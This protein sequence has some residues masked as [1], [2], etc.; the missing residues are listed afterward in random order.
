[1]NQI[2][3]AE[4]KR[5]PRV[6]LEGRC[7]LLAAVE[8]GVVAMFLR[9]KPKIVVFHLDLRSSLSRWISLGKESL[10]LKI[11]VMGFGKCYFFKG[12]S[13]SGGMKQ[14]PTVNL[15]NL[16]P[17]SHPPRVGKS[18]PSLEKYPNWWLSSWWLQ[19][20]SSSSFLRPWGSLQEAGRTPKWKNRKKK[21]LWPCY[22]SY[23]YPLPCATVC[24]WH[25]WYST[26]V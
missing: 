4:G 8:Y 5:N 17:L 10:P 22:E 16:K 25:G 6:Y 26:G 18:R 2:C 23:A 13:A 3:P 21:K 14:F 19:L 12:W 9:W 20:G 1:M 11:K 7:Y 15:G 24:R